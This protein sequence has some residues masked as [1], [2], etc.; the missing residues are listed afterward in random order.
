MSRLLVL[1]ACVSAIVGLS[2]YQKKPSTSDGIGYRLL[3]PEGYRGWLIAE[4]VRKAPPTPVV[5]GRYEYRFSKK[6]YLA[7]RPDKDDRWHPIDECFF[8]S[9]SGKYRRVPRA[10]EHE[11]EKFKKSNAVAVWGGHSSSRIDVDGPVRKSVEFESWFV[12]TYREWSTAGS[13]PSL[14]YVEG[15]RNGANR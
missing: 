11:E 15:V 6:G 1:I 2:A 12:G 14:K 9:T 7:I 3:L 10:L 8:V 4:H 5:K 13:L